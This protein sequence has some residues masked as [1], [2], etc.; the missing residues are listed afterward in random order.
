LY[1]SG[2]F[3][4][5]RIQKLNAC[6]CSTNDKAFAVAVAEQVWFLFF[7]G[8]TSLFLL[9]MISHLNGEGLILTSVETIEIASTLALCLHFVPTLIGVFSRCSHLGQAPNAMQ[10]PWFTLLNQVKLSNSNVT[11]MWQALHY[12][13]C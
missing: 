1:I 6:T 4:W 2:S 9:Q 10:E 13:Q 3:E 11:L 12:P 8:L 5:L 7:K